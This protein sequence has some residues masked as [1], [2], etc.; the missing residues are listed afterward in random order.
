MS[1]SD[2][3][4]TPSTRSR[5]IGH[6]LLPRLVFKPSATVTTGGSLSTIAPAF[7]E[8]AASSHALGSAANTL[9]RGSIDWRDGW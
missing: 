4:T 3:T 9:M 5:T 8:R 7:F 6:V 1:S 2:T